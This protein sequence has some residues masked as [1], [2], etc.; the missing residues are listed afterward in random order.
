MKEIKAF[1]DFV[2]V[3][4]FTFRQ[5]HTRKE[6]EKYKKTKHSQIMTT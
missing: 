6:N 2:F 1:F 4:L 3:D 5:I